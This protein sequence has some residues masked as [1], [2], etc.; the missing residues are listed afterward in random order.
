GMDPHLLGTL[1]QPARKGGLHEHL[2]SGQGDAALGG[3]EDTTG[4]STIKGVKQFISG[5]SDISVA[6]DIKFNY[7]KGF[8]RLN[9][10]GKIAFTKHNIRTGCYFLM[11]S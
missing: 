2:S 5:T 4:S 1:Q 8:I 3:A 9:E 7:P 10:K 11:F 6:E